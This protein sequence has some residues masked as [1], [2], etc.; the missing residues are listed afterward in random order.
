MQLWIDFE[1]P[2]FVEGKDIAGIAG[3][4]A[5]GVCAA[6]ATS[7]MGVPPSESPEVR[8]KEQ[9]LAAAKQAKAA[10]ELPLTLAEKKL[11]AACDRIERLLTSLNVKASA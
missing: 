4:M 11:A 5:N 1:R 9:E 7:L 10:A 8:A 2:Q 3:W 6:P